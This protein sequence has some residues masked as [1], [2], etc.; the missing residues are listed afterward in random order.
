[1]SGRKGQPQKPACLTSK[2]D[3]LVGHAAREETVSFLTAAYGEGYLTAE[4]HDTRTAQAL[5]AQTV[6]DLRC[7]VAELPSP[8]RTAGS[9]EM[10]LHPVPPAVRWLRYAATACATA[11]ICMW[12]VAGTNGNCTNGNC[13]AACA[14]AITGFFA[15]LLFLVSV[16]AAAEMSG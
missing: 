1:M 4:Q 8:L 11:C 16:A 9:R 13:P 15:V 12:A 3:G 14:A 2:W 10:Q 7:A 6:Y 5:T